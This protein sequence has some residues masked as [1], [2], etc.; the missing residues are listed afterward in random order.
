[1]KWLRNKIAWLRIRLHE[2]RNPEK[3]RI[4]RDVAALDGHP[5]LMTF[6]CSDDFDTGGK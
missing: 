6:D 1:M 4:V 2:W 3:S 5:G